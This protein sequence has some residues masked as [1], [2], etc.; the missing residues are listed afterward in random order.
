MKE[1]FVY[2][3]D[4]ENKMLWIVLTEDE[5]SRRMLFLVIWVSLPFKDDSLHSFRITG[6]YRSK[7]NACPDF[8]YHFTA[9]ND[10]WSD[11]VLQN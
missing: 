4:T 5:E 10:H 11:Y 6:S 9:H 1:R 2:V 3:C 7:C 8:Q